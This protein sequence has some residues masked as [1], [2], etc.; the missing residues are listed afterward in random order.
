N[1]NN[2]YGLTPAGVIVNPAVSDAYAV[3]PALHS[4]AKDKASRFP[5]LGLFKDNR[6]DK[7][8]LKGTFVL[9]APYGNGKTNS[10]LT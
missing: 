8:E 5:V 2:A 7:N 4:L 3:R 1:A 10:T 9:P 6:A